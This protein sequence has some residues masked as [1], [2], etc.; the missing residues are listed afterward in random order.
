MAIPALPFIAAGVIGYL[1]IANPRV[2]RLDRQ[3]TVLSICV[4]ALFIVLMA[5]RYVNALVR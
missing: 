3:E 2:R 5:A 1:L 4:A